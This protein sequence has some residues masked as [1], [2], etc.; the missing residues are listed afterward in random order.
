MQFLSN[1]T[2]VENPAR[3]MPN[4]FDSYVMS[5]VKNALKESG[6]VINNALTLNVKSPASPDLTIE[7]I[8]YS[9]EVSPG[10]LVAM[11]RLAH[12]VGFGFYDTSCALVVHP[13]L[14]TWFGLRSV[15]LFNAVDARGEP[16]KGS[17]LV[18][19]MSQALAQRAQDE[20]PNDET[21]INPLDLFLH[22][23]EPVL[24]PATL[25]NPCL[26]SGCADAHAQTCKDLIAKKTRIRPLELRSASDGNSQTEPE[27]PLYRDSSLWDEPSTAWLL[28]R[29]QCLV[30][31]KKQT[32][33]DAEGKSESLEGKRP[34]GPGEVS[35]ANPTAICITP[36]FIAQYRPNPWRYS[37]GQLLYHYT[38]SRDILAEELTSFNK[39]YNL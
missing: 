11:Q 2:E 20:G 7:D 24:E 33:P 37:D 15:L 3:D 12:A 27:E 38:L 21:G 31:R 6:L 13:V 18:S 23:P 1:V 8:R 16:I 26:A 10:R 29:E 36:E 30:G 34:A 9:F 22:I 14:S 35:L 5:S 19:E 28:L 39:R 32:K 17:D 4:P 25:P